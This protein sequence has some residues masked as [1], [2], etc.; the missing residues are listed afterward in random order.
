MAA[1]AE[2]R[3]IPI[4]DQYDHMRRQG[5][6]RRDARWPHDSHWNAAGYQW[7]AEALLDWLKQN[8]DVCTMHKRP[9]SP[10]RPP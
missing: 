2:A 10:P 3:G 1:L 7:A 4:I 8:Q 5:A 9:A 6:E